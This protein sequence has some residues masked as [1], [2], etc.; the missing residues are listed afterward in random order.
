MSKLTDEAKNIIQNVGGLEN[1]DNLSNCVTRLRFN[2]NDESKV[3]EEYFEQLEGIIGHRFQSGQFQVII[4]GEVGKVAKAINNEY[5]SLENEKT[6][7]TEPPK[8]EKAWWE[9]IIDILSSTL[10]R[11][12]PAIIGAGMLKGIL[13]M[14]TTFSILNP[15]SDTYT[16][17][18]VAAD[19]TFYFLPFLVASSAAKT[20]RT[21]EAISLALAGALM[22]PSILDVANI[23]EITSYDFLGFFSI[24]IINYSA[25]VIP[26]IL[27][28]WILSHL[29]NF[30]D[31]KIHSS[32]TTV[33]TP[34]ISLLVMV[35]VLLGILAPIG[36][37]LGDYVARG[38]S[39][40]IGFSPIIA[41]FVVGAS[42]PFL[43]LTGMHHALGPIILQE[44]ATYGASSM[45]PMNLM[46]TFAQ[47]TAALTLFFVLNDKKSKQITAS[48]S[49]SGY[50]GITEP[51]LYGPLTTYPAAFLGATI[52]GGIGGAVSAILGAQS[53]A[54]VM[55]SIFTIPVYFAG[56]A[57]AVLI[58]IVVA[59]I[60]TFFITL[61]L[62]KV[63]NRKESVNTDITAVTNNETKD[64]IYSPVKGRVYP[65]K[66]VIDS[67]FSD[68]IMG[69]S[70]VIYPESNEIVSPIDGVV[71]MVFDTRHAV[72]ITSD[73][74]LELLIH[75]GIDTVSL[76][77][78][79]F[80]SFVEKGD[81]VSIG[82]KILD[83]DVNYIQENQLDPSVIMIITNSDTVTL[84]KIH[85]SEEQID[86]IEKVMQKQLEAN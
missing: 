65:I 22:Y 8:E 17:L 23:G 4:G 50:I 66:D 18:N 34:L 60:S 73:E 13:F 68:E 19:S 3:N 49:F 72:G 46:S 52:G 7:N 28:V 61:G 30:L 85:N 5:P 51:A 86:R 1:I 20:Y 24:P 56:G 54:H 53:Y 81:R 26:I 75:V 37:Y 76:D 71:T 77:G 11:A 45:G 62:M 58:A 12:L 48:A 67:T 84:D 39:W 14:L 15:E 83:V 41:G 79:G 80:K 74:G 78:E 10:S 27:G 36:F 2:L 32:V 69:T 44:I 9:K 16:V 57:S 40:L 63:M 70:V 33:F 35:P 38:I 25:S 47:A 42:R 64:G 6:S 43:V 29:Y 55:G 31:D 59:I 21:N 82:D